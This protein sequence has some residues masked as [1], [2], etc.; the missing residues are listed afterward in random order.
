[1]LLISEIF[2]VALIINFIIMQKFNF[3]HKVGVMVVRIKTPV[4]IP[5]SPTIKSTVLVPALRVNLFLSAHKDKLNA[6]RNSKNN[7]CITITRI[8][9]QAYRIIWVTSTRTKL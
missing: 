5:L 8:A 6:I 4:V 3:L 9:V 2:L 7:I 1:M